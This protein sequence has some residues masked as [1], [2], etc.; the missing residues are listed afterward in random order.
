M[1]DALRAFA[2]EERP[3]RASAFCRLLHLGRGN[4][5]TEVRWKQQGD[6]Y[7]RKTSNME[8]MFLPKTVLLYFAGVPADTFPFF[9]IRMW[10]AHYMHFKPSSCQSE[11]HDPAKGMMQP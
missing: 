9:C 6:L 5:Q 10:A 1:V 11:F 8:S 2:A 3:Q 7:Y 4:G